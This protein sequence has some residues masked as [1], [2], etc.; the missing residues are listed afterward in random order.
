MAYIK[1]RG[2]YCLLNSGNAQCSDVF[3]CQGIETS[4]KD[5]YE[6]I[7]PSKICV[8]RAILLIIDDLT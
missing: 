3:H 8:A 6:N 4:K 5:Y 2:A 7:R 1:E